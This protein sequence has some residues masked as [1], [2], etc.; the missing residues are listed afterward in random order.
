MKN[1][2]TLRIEHLSGQMLMKIFPQQNQQWTMSHT[3][4]VLFNQVH[5]IYF[6][7][8]KSIKKVPYIIKYRIITI[9]QNTEFQEK[10][11]SE[12]DSVGDEAGSQTA[13]K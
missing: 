11:D 1:K 5:I 12:I 6:D 7:F 9:L 4:L 10:T 3:K 13:N 8:I 2:H